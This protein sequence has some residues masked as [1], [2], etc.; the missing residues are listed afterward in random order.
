M[1]FHLHIV[2]KK[3]EVRITEKRRT[4]NEMLDR[5]HFSEDSQTCRIYLHVFDWQ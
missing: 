5:L 2:R 3:E 1:W 4:S